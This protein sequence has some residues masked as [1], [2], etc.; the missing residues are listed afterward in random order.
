MTKVKNSIK[1]QNFKIFYTYNLI[2]ITPNNLKLKTKY[3]MYL[4]IMKNSNICKKKDKKKC[5]V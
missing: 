4:W 2:H 5:L 1:I 3:I